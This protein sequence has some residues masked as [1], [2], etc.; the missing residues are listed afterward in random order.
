MEHMPA[1]GGTIPMQRPCI[2]KDCPANGGCPLDGLL[3]GW[4]GWLAGL[5]A[6][7]LRI[8]MQRPCINNPIWSRCLPRGRECLCN[9]F[10]LKNPMF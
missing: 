9:A 5:A 2:V 3:P 8:P 1:Q 6:R 4:L 7:E 10:V